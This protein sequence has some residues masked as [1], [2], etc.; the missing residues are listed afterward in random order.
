MIA[1]EKR[2]VN[3][4]SAAM[5]Q[6]SEAILLSVDPNSDSSV[7]RYRSLL[8]APA[9]DDNTSEEVDPNDVDFDVAEK[10]AMNVLQSALHTA[11][12]D[13]A[14]VIRRC[15]SLYNRSAH[16]A[17][18][19]ELVPRFEASFERELALLFPGRQNV[20][21]CT[22]VP[23]P[24]ADELHRNGEQA[25][26]GAAANESAIVDDGQQPESAFRRGRRRSLSF[27]KRGSI[28]SIRGRLNEQGQAVNG[29]ADESGRT[30]RQE[31][32]A[33]NRSQSRTR[34]SLF[35][36]RPSMDSRPG[37]AAGNHTP[38]LKKRISFLS[39]GRS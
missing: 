25:V 23:S 10:P 3:A 36:R 35:E 2:V 30:S 6:L 8:P 11:L 27:L 29:T 7:A 32:H 26:D 28:S 9:T 39:N 22:H 34:L 21:D 17:T 37:S 38:T 24:D 13:H 14:L 19:A 5:S 33:R 4:D 12:L 1:L 15:L 16:A 20:M 31:G 18:R